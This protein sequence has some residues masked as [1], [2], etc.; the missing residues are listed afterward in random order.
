[1]FANKA[2]I[3]LI[4]LLT[5]A[6]ATA[7]QARYSEHQHVSH[8]RTHFCWQKVHKKR[9]RLWI[10]KNHW[11]YERRHL[12]AGMKVRLY[13]LRMCESTNNYRAVN[14]IYTGA[15]QYAASTW[16][17]AGGHG[18]AMD[19]SPAEQ[20][21]RTAYFYPEHQGEWECAA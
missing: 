4:A 17:R 14:G 9:V 12:P 15:Y 5:L 6:F 21:V 8:C 2:R 11:R 18:Q 10:Q 20:D 3:V 7:A 16:A 1:M 13:H 19:A